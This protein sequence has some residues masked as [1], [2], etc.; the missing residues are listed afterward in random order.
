MKVA[1]TM[2]LSHLSS[3]LCRL[4]SHP[5]R[6]S[7]RSLSLLVFV[8]C[9][10]LDSEFTCC[11]WSTP[12]FCLLT[13]VSDIL[14]LRFFLFSINIVCEAHSHIFSSSSFDFT[15]VWYPIFW[16][17]LYLI[18]L[19]NCIVSNFLLLGYKASVLLCVS[20]C[21]CARI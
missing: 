12:G 5:Q 13:C 19:E 10:D 8:P 1:G 16:L 2:K 14:L 11:L 6:C 18:L 3:F 21:T 7:P 20:S 17:H 9:S 15:A 4:P